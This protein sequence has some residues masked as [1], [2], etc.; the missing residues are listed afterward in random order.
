MQAI[1]PTAPSARLTAF[2]PQ[3]QYTK[4]V[5]TDVQATWRRHGWAAPDPRQQRMV[6]NM[7][8]SLS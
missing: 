8:N 3:F 1:R 7:L 5:N 4:S 6:R 2:P